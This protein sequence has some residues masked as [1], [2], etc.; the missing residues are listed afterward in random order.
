MIKT[1]AFAFT[2]AALLTVQAYSLDVTITCRVCSGTLCES[3][4]CM[5][6]VGSDGYKE[7]VC[8]AKGK[9]CNTA[10]NTSVQLANCTVDYKN[11]NCTS[12]ACFLLA[13]KLVSRSTDS[14]CA[15]PTYR[16]TTCGVTCTECTQAG[17]S[18]CVAVAAGPVD[19]TAT[20][21]GNECASQCGVSVVKSKT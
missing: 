17:Q 11:D 15:T 20:T 6:L 4:Y 16:N 12:G 10:M 19:G 2:L 1:I 8:V 7:L 18:K 3:T 13:D 14:P 9:T 21:S 5:D